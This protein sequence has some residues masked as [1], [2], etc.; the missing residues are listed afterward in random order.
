[1]DYI[2]RFSEIIHTGN[3]WNRSYTIQGDNVDLSHAHA[4]CKLRTANDELIL[5]A[6]CT[7]HDKSIYVSIPAAKSLTIP[8][9]LFKG[10]YDVFITSDTYSYK[11]VMGSIKIIHD[12]S[13]H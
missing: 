10:F 13:L 8:K 12:I 3:D 11:L 6:D 5:E 7:I 1:M 9:T 2:K 4:V